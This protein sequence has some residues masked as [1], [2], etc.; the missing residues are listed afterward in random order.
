MSNRNLDLK[1]RV[2]AEGFQDAENRLRGLSSEVDRT[3]T[4]S[5]NTGKAQDRMA[6][7]TQQLGQSAGRARSD[8]ERM[9]QSVSRLRG[10][11]LRATAA[12]GGTV[13]LV[14]GIR[15]FVNT[16]ADY[17]QSMAKVQAV[18]GATG[19]EM[20]RLDA[21]A[22][23]MG[24]STT[25]SASQAAEGIEFLGRAGFETGQIVEALPQMLSLAEAASLDLGS[26]ADITSNIMSAFK[27]EAE[28]TGTIVDAL[29]AASQ[30]ANTDVRQLGS[31]MAVVGPIA[32]ALG[33]S[34]QDAAAAIGTLSNA[35]IQG[36]RAGTGLRAVLGSLANP[37]AQA[38]RALES[39]GLSVADVNP[40]ANS[41]TEVVRRLEEA[42]LDANRAFQIFGRQATPAIL[43]LTG[44][45][46]GF[47]EL[48]LRINDS[49]GA[50]RDAAETMRN[51][52]RGAVTSL[53]SAFEGLILS[54]NEQTGIIGHLKELADTM[55]DE[56]AENSEQLA[57]RA[58]TAF[59][60]M[61]GA[62]KA[63]AG[64]VQVAFNTVQVAGAALMSQLVGAAANASDALSKITFG[65]ISERFRREAE[66]LRTTSQEL[67]DEARKNADELVEASFKARD[68][69]AQIAEG[70]AELGRE[71]KTSDPVRTI[72]EELQHLVG[73]A[74]EAA[75][76]IDKL[77]D[78]LDGASNDAADAAN[79]FRTI[80][81]ELD[82]VEQRAFAT[83]DAMAA[84]GEEARAA[85]GE[86]TDAISEIE[87]AF[88]ELGFTSTAVLEAKA[89]KATEAYRLIVEGAKNGEASIH[90]VNQAYAVMVQRQLEVAQGAEQAAQREVAANLRR[91]ASTDEQRETVEDLIERYL[92]L[93]AKS[94]E[95]GERA[96]SAHRRAASAAREQAS[97]VRS[98]AD[99]ASQGPTLGRATTAEGRDGGGDD[100]R[101]SLAEALSG[102]EVDILGPATS[103]L[104]D[105]EDRNRLLAEANARLDRALNNV[106]VRG[107]AGARRLMQTQQAILQDVQREAQRLAGVRPDSD[108][109]LRERFRRDED[110]QPPSVARRT[111]DVRLSDGGGES[112]TVQAEEQDVQPLL[113]MLE[114]SRSVSSQGA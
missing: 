45:A 57:T 60:I 10:T 81:E 73:K 108:A 23:E 58:G 18:T 39:L 101:T 20:S 97:A 54:T 86:A 52:L 27:V 3:G 41:L 74:P 64:S 110:G 11:V 30:E 75:G 105:P 99:A 63:M 77:G 47:D 26:A 42:N 72:N 98:V 83:G 106:E 59:D 109:A 111:V 53:R 51:T 104:L 92:D 71:V 76:E 7:S 87:A 68:G 22:R 5:R 102:S 24:S 1:L 32:E 37:T 50:A 8:S 67:R 100:E 69:F 82:T 28:E 13:G 80:G 43:A 56:V 9:T 78:S 79:Q 2:L 36:Q 46:D 49:E 96:E 14:A 94:E 31:A 85:A 16:S 33:I 113:R 88:E 6:R 38:T 25:F 19:D 103:A 70:V 90:D 93:G 65:N 40:E 21:V 84:I 62:A 107:A 29:V 44:N 66:N 95:A 114:R 61:G 91:K 15:S 112:V 55:R 34:T 17:E 4:S 48:A 12:L 89:Q 35:G